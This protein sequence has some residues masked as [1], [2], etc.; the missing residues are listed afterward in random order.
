MQGLSDRESKRLIRYHGQSIRLL[1]EAI[2]QARQ[3]RWLRC[4]DLLWGGLTLAVKGVALSRG[5]DLPDQQAVEDYA[6]RLGN[7]HRDRRIREAFTRLRS[8]TDT[9]EQVH[10][11]RARG[12]RLIGV[13][14]DL[15]GAIERLWGLLP[16]EQIWGLLP[17][18][19][20]LEDDEWDE[21]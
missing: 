1:K 9:A 13:F 3:G 7:E 16:M 12:D 4:E 19:P 5:D 20:P 17:E 2:E 6:Q 21:R 18:E 10:E 14:E 8:F 15:S 11:S